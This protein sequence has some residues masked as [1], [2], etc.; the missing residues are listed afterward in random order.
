MMTAVHSVTGAATHWDDAYRLGH[1]TRSWYQQQPQPSLAMLDAVGATTD[2]RLIDVGGGA[3]S[4][5]DALLARGYR[6]LTV[7]DISREGLHV[8]QTR[9][10]TAAERVHWIVADLLAWEPQR[11]WDIWHDRAVLHFFTDDAAR[12]RYCDTLNRATDPDSVA[13]L[14]TFAPDGPERCS[15]LAVHRYDAGRLAALLGERWQLVD[16]RRD[17]HSTPSGGVQP[18]TW[19]AF[20][21]RS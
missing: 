9:L 11:T 16:D 17:L 18:F 6:D 5:V 8:A 12:A 19:A 20:R 15:G 21:K 3:A 7:L 10:G 1:N 4:L 14:A 2:A 13:I